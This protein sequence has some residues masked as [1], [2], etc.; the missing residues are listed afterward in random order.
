LA[1]AI[2]GAADAS[3]TQSSRTFKSTTSIVFLGPD[4][5]LSR[6]S[7]TEALFSAGDK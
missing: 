1:C 4:N 2:G 3:V 7:T 6:L 5:F